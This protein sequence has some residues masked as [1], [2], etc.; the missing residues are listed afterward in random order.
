MLVLLPDD[1]DAS[2]EQIRDRIRELTGREVAVLITDITSM[3][4]RR[5]QS[6][7]PKVSKPMSTEKPSRNEGEYFAHQNAEL[8]RKQREPRRGRGPGDR[9]EDPLH[10]VSQGRTRSRHSDF[11]GVQI[12]TCPHC[13]GIW[14]DAGEPDTWHTSTPR[15]AHPADPDG[16]E[17]LRAERSREPR[18]EQPRG[19]RRARGHLLP[20]RA[21][22]HP[23][24]GARAQPERAGVR[25]ASSRCWAA[26][27]RSPSWACSRRC[28]RSTALQAFEAGSQDL[29]R[30]PARTSS[31]A[32]RERRR[33]APARGLGGGVQDRVAQSPVGGRA[34]SGRRD[35]GGRHPARR[36]HHGR[37]TGGGAQQPALRPARSAPEP[38]SLRRGRARRG[39]LRQLRRRADAR[40]GRS[41]SLRATP[42]IRW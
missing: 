34:L 10:E 12:E 14:L 19:G 7:L 9:A 15:P 40:V 41:A 5:P 30:P 18:R 38:L 20:R 33:A 6:P 13:G 35:R 4:A 36:L 23:R 8:I 21:S 28:G 17:A 11:H 31:R 16:F 24:G 2:A 27:R 42:A 39:R 1:P 25:A 29:S 37:P 32:R 22:G 26:R 3:V